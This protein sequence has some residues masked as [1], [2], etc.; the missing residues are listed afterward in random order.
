[1]APNWAL[2][3]GCDCRSCPTMEWGRDRRYH[4]LL[5]DCPPGRD[6]ERKL[7]LPPESCTAGTFCDPKPRLIWTRMSPWANLLTENVTAECHTAKTA[8]Y[9]QTCA[10]GGRTSARTAHPNGLP[11]QT[12]CN[13]LD[14][15]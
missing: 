1:M 13:S 15:F 14:A 5:L 11:A 9:A 10:F 7:S 4:S 12:V 6:W 3:A 2:P 8:L